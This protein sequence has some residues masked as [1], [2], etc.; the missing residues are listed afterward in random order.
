MQIGSDDL[1]LGFVK[2]FEIGDD[3]AEG[4]VRLFRFQVADV[5]ADENLIADRKRDGVFQMRAHRQNNS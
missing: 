4:G 2:F 5:L 1:R 3:A